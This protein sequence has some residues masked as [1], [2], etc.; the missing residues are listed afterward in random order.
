MEA[1]VRRH[2]ALAI[3]GGAI[4]TKQMIENEARGIPDDL[5]FGDLFRRRFGEP[6]PQA[7]S[8]LGSGFIVS[9]EGHIVTNNHVVDNASEI[10]VRFTDKTDVPAKLVGRDPSTDVAVLKIE[11]RPN[12]AVV[13]WGDSDK[14]EPGA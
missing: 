5:P 11:P 9:A 6:R 13:A 4:L 12:M 2:A 7:R 3:S 14:M 8:A 1:N 10:H